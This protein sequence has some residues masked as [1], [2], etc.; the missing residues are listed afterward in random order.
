MTKCF[1]QKTKTE[2]II[3][4][5]SPVVMSEHFS[6]AFSIQSSHVSESVEEKEARTMGLPI[7]GKENE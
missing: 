2:F 7:A 3:Q 1:G 4:I 6:S 5:K